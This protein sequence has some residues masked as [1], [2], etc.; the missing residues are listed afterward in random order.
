MKKSEVSQSL[1]KNGMMIESMQAA[2]ETKY[3]V[4]LIQIMNEIYDQYLV[5]LPQDLNEALKMAQEAKE[6]LLKKYI[7]RIVEMK[8]D[9]ESS[10]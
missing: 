4:P 1:I 10:N 5:D 7:D 2:N 8:E 6:E 3:D 9:S